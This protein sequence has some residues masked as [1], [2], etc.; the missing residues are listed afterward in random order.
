MFGGSSPSGGSTAGAAIGGSSSTGIAQC[1][2]S[3]LGLGGSSPMAA[4]GATVTVDLTDEGGSENVLVDEKLDGEEFD[5][6]ACCNFGSPIKVEWDGKTHDFV[7]GFGL[8]SPTRWKPNARGHRRKQVMKE[9]AATTFSCLSHGVADAIGDVRREAFKLVTGKLTASPFSNELLDKVR[10]QIAALLR[11]PGGALVRDAGQ[12]FYLRLLAQWLEVFEDP[13]VAC[14]VSSTDSFATGVNVGVD[15]ALPRTPQVFHPKLKHRKLDGTEF[16][17]IADNYSSGQMSAKELE[18][19]FREEEALGRME[20]SKLSVL[21]AQHGDRLRVAAMA[22]IVKPDG[23]IRPLHDAT[24]SVMVNHAIKYRDQLQCPG[25][26]EV[27]AVVREAIETTEAPFCVSADIK[28]AH[29]LVKIREADWPYVCC[30]ADSLSEVVWINKVGTFGVSSAPYWWAKLL[31]AIGRFVGHVM[32]TS[33][34]WHLVYVDDLHGAFTG[35]SKFELLW[36]WLLAFEVIGTPFGYHKFKGGF[37]SDFVGFHLRYDRNEVGITVKR[38]TWL[39]DWIRALEGKKFVVSAREFSEFLGRLGF[40]AQ[41]LTWLKPHLAPLFAWGA[42]ASPGMV[43][44]LPDTVILTL[45]YILKEMAAETFMVSAR[46]PIYFNSEQ[47]R[48][49]AKCADDFIVLGGWELSSKRWFS[50]RL[51]RDQVPYMFKPDGGGSQWASTSAELLASLCALHAFGWL[52]PS[53]RRT[54]ALALQAGT[55]NRANEALSTKRSTTKW[56]LMLINMQLSASLARAR[57]SLNLKW[58]P[59]EENV[60]ADKL[61]NEE[62]DSFD[63]ACRIDIKW[64]EF[65]MSLVGA[66]W[67][68][69]VQFDAARQ[70]TKLD[71]AAPVASKKRKHEKTPW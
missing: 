28:A 10:T 53:S 39:V 57:L 25:P 61:T 63:A 3:G 17:P 20:P 15:S 58:R 48:T 67:E 23:G 29:R 9:L 21:K 70:S 5:V 16:N 54:V 33:V 43:G 51:N 52:D 46:R 41:L 26:A 22:A 34:F 13:D 68:T 18:E 56:P 60:E 42:V 66:L 49:D 24:H 27:A 19:K 12:P 11:D 1:H 40:V 30:R 36:V 59:R 62:F 38:G 6:E 7:D 32:Q 35:P 8:C 37:S 45:H 44:R 4:K 2:N 50:L 64:G 65:D 69:K 55:D 14:L 31:A 47:F 71:H